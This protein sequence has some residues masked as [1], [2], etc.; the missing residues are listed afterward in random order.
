MKD[1]EFML[2][3]LFGKKALE[4]CGNLA[5]CIHTRF[6]E[7]LEKVL[8]TYWCQKYTC[9]SGWLIEDDKVSYDV[10]EKICYAVSLADLQKEGETHQPAERKQ[11]TLK[12]LPKPIRQAIG[13]FFPI[14]WKTYLWYRGRP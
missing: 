11:M 3:A 6:Q 5:D 7:H 9:A 4:G 10:G 2:Y 14:F 13:S 12:E 8:P 1:F